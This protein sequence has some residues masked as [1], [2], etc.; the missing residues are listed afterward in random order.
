[1]ADLIKAYSE[2]TMECSFVGIQ[3]GEKDRVDG[4]F[5]SIWHSWF[6][7][8]RFDQLESQAEDAFLERFPEAKSPV[9]LMRIKE[10]APFEY[11][12]GMFLQKG[13]SVPP[14]FDKLDF[15]PMSFWVGWIKGQEPDIYHA[16]EL[17]FE[18]LGAAGREPELD[19]EGYLLLL[20]RYTHPRFTKR[21]E[22]GQ[23]IL[24][25]LVRI[26]PTEDEKIE[27][28]DE[29]ASAEGLYYCANCRKESKEETCAECGDKGTPLLMDDPIFIG[30]LPGR[31]RNALQ[32]AFGATDI[33]FNALANL[34]SGFTLAAGDLFE[35]YRIYVPY[36]RA[37]EAKAA[38]DSV[39][40]IN[41]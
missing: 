16:D 23:A 39:F 36:E 2:V 40:K 41:E 24:D 17:V 38:F 5:A 34:G 31:L 19:T 1:M 35:S 37:K 8:R 25:V 4:S 30:I 21:D 3:Y 15:P 29:E 11:W 28:K 33:P 27:I 7:N 9:G 26:K 32:L 18:S 12:V 14:G 22:E 20:E 13:A 6:D 10:G